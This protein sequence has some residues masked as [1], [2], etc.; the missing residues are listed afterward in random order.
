MSRCDLQ[1]VYAPHPIFKQV[2]EPVTEVNA[3]I[4][5]IIDAMFDVLQIEKGIGIGAN[6]VGVLKR[7]VVI[8][9]QQDD[10]THRIAMVNPDIVSVSDG[11][12]TFEEASLSFPGISAEI[13]RPKSITVQFL[14]YDGVEQTLEAEGFLSTVIQ[15]EIDYLDGT[16]YLDYLSKLKRDRLLKKMEKYQKLHPPHVHT[17]DC[18]TGCRH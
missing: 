16:V 13:T 5:G 6:M 17:P 2:A 11:T 15:H 10:I 8:H 1:L 7:I 3:D 4:Q 9:M 14:D 12:H 18:S